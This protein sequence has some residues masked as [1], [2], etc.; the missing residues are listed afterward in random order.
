MIIETI[1]DLLELQENHEVE[2]KSAQ[3]RNGNGELPDDFFETYCA[4]A[5]SYGGSVFLGIKEHKDKSLEILGIKH[6]DKVKK[7]L[8]DSLNNKQKISL[9][10]LS[11][12]DIVEINLEEKLII[13]IIIP[14]ASRQ[15]RPIYE[16]T[17]P[18]VG[19]Y[20]R[21]F[22]GDY[23]CDEAK[24]KRMI[25]EQLDESRDV[26]LLEGYT[27]DDIDLESLSNYRNIFGVL[28]PD[29]PW[30]TIDDLEFLRSIGGYKK[31]RKNSL[32]GLTLAGLLMFGKLP[33]IQD[34]LSN[35][36][37]DYQELPED[38]SEH[39]WIDRVTIDGTWSGN[40]FDFYK[41]VIRKLHSD[42]KVPFVLEGDN[43][44]DETAIHKA[45]REAFI[46]MLVHA[47]YGGRATLKVLKT[48][49]G[50][51]FKN[52]G[53]MRIPIED[54]FHGGESDCRN[55]TLH[56]MFLLISLG[57]RAGSGLPKILSAWKSQGWIEPS[58]REKLIPEQTIL[59][60]STLTFLPSELSDTTPKVRSLTPKV[61]HDL[62]QLLD[63][64]SEI[65]FNLAKPVSE[66]KRVSMEVTKKTILN[67]CEQYYL[68]LPLLAKLLNRSEVAL[69]Q[70]FINPM[71]MNDH[72]LER[73]F[74]QTPN[75]P[76]QAYK[77]V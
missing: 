14:R 16:G 34:E 76:K 65:L 23:R 61:V 72:T 44:Q 60:L 19:T 66:H 54:A 46:N 38:I 73:A 71:V 64:E 39:R 42:L 4:M 8:F 52:P 13:Q 63:K 26:R 29:H 36:M 75:H 30:N 37:L 67:L 33:S 11:D 43:R 3:G 40:I 35:Y 31:D 24:V 12:A 49:N 20:I 55:R 51:S 70:G 59:E 68:S 47:E 18:L 74:P 56:Q 10:I 5:N 58:I 6:T 69:R 9:N 57:E 32:E 15:E 17:N 77:K 21:N 2:F 7:K 48:P 27:L 1:E 22:E 41:K 53:L 62:G 25:S 28:K 50:F 45:L